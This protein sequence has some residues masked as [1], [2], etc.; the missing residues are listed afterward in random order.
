MHFQNNDFTVYEEIKCMLACLNSSK[1][2]QNSTISVQLAPFL[3]YSIIQQ[4][5]RILSYTIHQTFI[6]YK[7]GR[8]M[9]F[10]IVEHIKLIL[11]KRLTRYF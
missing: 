7:T 10:Y 3:L 9:Q 5:P 6:N 8:F 1:Y 4:R 2:L 11:I